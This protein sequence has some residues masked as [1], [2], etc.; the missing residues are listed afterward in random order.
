MKYN[1]ENI[2][3]HVNRLKDDLSQVNTKHIHGEWDWARTPKLYDM[4]NTILF[5]FTKYFSYVDSSSIS[6]NDFSSFVDVL[7]SNVYSLSKDEKSKNVLDDAVRISRN[8][9]PKPPSA[10]SP[11][12]I[13]LCFLKDR[14]EPKNLVEQQILALKLLLESVKKETTISDDAV[15]ELLKAT[16][17]MHPYLQVGFVTSLLMCGEI[18][19]TLKISLMLKKN[20][21]VWVAIS[22]FCHK[23]F[24][25]SNEIFCHV[26]K[27]PSNSIPSVI[28]SISDFLNDNKKL[29]RTF[30]ELSAIAS[31]LPMC[32][33]DEKSNQMGEKR[34][35]YVPYK[36]YNSGQNDL[37]I[38]FIK[39]SQSKIDEQTLQLKCLS[40]FAAGH[41]KKVIE[42]YDDYC[43]K[44]AS[45]PKNPRTKSAY[46]LASAFLYKFEYKFSKETEKNKK[47]DIDYCI[48]NLG[49]EGK[50]IDEVLNELWGK[51]DNQCTMTNSSESYFN[52]NNLF[53]WHCFKD[54]NKII[55]YYKNY[56]KSYP[57]MGGEPYE[58][59]KGSLCYFTAFAHLE[60]FHTEE[61]KK[62]KDLAKFRTFIKEKLSEYC[63]KSGSLY[64]AYKNI[65]EAYSVNEN[66]FLRSTRFLSVAPEINAKE[67]TD[68]QNCWLECLYF[69]FLTFKIQDR[70]AIHSDT[71]QSQ[72][73]GT[74]MSLERYRQNIVEIKN[75][76][77]PLLNATT[78]S[79]PMEG[80]LLQFDGFST[81]HEKWLNDP[82]VYLRALS[83]LYDNLPMWDRYADNGKGVYA[84]MSKDMLY[85]SNTDIEP[86]NINAP[87]SRKILRLE[88]G[89]KMYRVAYLKIGDGNSKILDG[90]EESI[91]VTHVGGLTRKE[92]TKTKSVTTQSEIKNAKKP[93]HKID[94]KH[95][96]EDFEDLLRRYMIL[97]NQLIKE[98]NCSS[99]ILKLVHYYH[100]KIRYLFKSH[101]F[102][103]E[104]E[105]RLISFNFQTKE[106]IKL[107]DKYIQRVYWTRPIKIDHVIIGP[108]AN[109]FRSLVPYLE[110]SVLKTKISV[111][112]NKRAIESTKNVICSK[113]E[114][115]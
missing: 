84:V 46:M 76:M 44:T 51:T 29:F 35:Q 71:L 10:K 90:N 49:M 6:E 77:L 11:T 72:T 52:A 96:C 104:D 12:D 24:E 19:N 68:Q 13:T 47:I 58:N 56:N 48:K 17:K 38:E 9:K 4:V 88:D 87:Y 114:I 60:K 2:I 95:Y 66:F 5:E 15:E 43:E 102:E 20:L 34:L 107:P 75:H 32:C 36:L 7:L 3:E 115:V 45:I 89:R 55:S 86:R 106:N 101:V 57:K 30:E 113:I 81:E 8:T 28:I 85:R 65:K 73:I 67:F 64:K 50:T 40:S 91:V 74:Y 80:E 98:K 14:I 112:A 79:D 21:D 27:M 94:A 82:K 31:C 70:L 110:D 59:Y 103:S 42:Y 41:Y 99:E 39:N 37:A 26:Y 78:M 108:K 92:E 18:C 97:G 16:Y 62:I 83:A 100:N 63:T 111:F 69:M 23:I 25:H 93:E 54:Y 1:E 105:I 22:D 53:V 33:N 109:D 61:C